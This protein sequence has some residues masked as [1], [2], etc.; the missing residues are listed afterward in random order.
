[1][2]VTADAL[3]KI[4]GWFDALD[5]ALFSWF[6]SEQTAAG[7]TGDVAEIGVYEGKSAILIG[8]Y[9]ER[10]EVFT[11]ID[12][13]EDPSEN[14]QTEAEQKAYA[15]LTQRV[16]EA[17]YLSFHPRL[18]TV[19]RG[20]S[21]SIL[22]HARAAAHRF[23]HIDG[24]HLYEDVRADLQSA[25]R[26]LD[27]GGIVA[28]DDFRSA[29]TPGVAAAAWESIVLGGLHG[30][31][32]SENKLYATWSDPDAWLKQLIAWLPRSGLGWE[33]QEVLRRPL[34]RVW[35]IAPQGRRVAEAVTPPALLRRIDR[36]R[37]LRRAGMSTGEVARFTARD[38]AAAV[39]R[40]VG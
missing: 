2:R 36:A 11:V 14:P 29:H 8:D 13:F 9:L 39:R 24:S 30:L 17:N 5:Q 25:R 20:E 7:R 23:V 33:Q 19:V 6:L 35:P 16:F 37:E 12:L 28:V 15:G 4:P 10:G 32:V 3:A 18:P 1:M 21:R 22:E 31:V 27:A 34:L 40:R 38:V 26:L